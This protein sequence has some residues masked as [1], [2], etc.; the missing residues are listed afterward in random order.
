MYQSNL[1]LKLTPV[2]DRVAGDI[3]VFQWFDA[4]K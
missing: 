3:A 4:A 1:P 2:M